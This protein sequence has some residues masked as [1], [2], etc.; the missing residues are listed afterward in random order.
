MNASK[1]P[2]ASV[3]RPAALVR[4]LSPRG[5]TA[6]P[7]VV[8]EVRTALDFLVSLVGDTEPELLPADA[9]WRANADDSLSAPLHR[10]VE[11]VFEHRAGAKGITGWA[12]IPLVI[13]RADVRTAADVVA[14]AATYGAARI[15]SA[16]SLVGALVACGASYGVYGMAPGTWLLSAAVALILWRHRGNIVR[17]VRHEEHRL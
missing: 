15:V 17:M 10:D 11:R 12:L 9:A 6:R 4:D 13:P 1:T 7:E 16:G 3:R 14:F 5:A 2:A 8:L